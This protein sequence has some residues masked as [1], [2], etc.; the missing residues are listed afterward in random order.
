MVRSDYCS[1]P[2]AEPTLKSVRGV[3]RP[4]RKE[5]AMLVDSNSS[6]P[7]A[8]VVDPIRGLCHDM[9]QPLAAI[10][11]LAETAGSDPQR[12]LDL[13]ADQARW[14][15]SLVDD[16]LVDAAGDDAGQVDVTACATRRGRRAA[17][18]DRL[19]AGPRRDRRGDGHRPPG[20]PHPGH[21]LPRRQRRPRG[22]R[23]TGRSSSTSRST[24][25]ATSRSPCATTVRGWATWRPGRHWGSPSPARSSRPSAARWTCARAARAVWSPPSAC[26]EY[27]AGPSPREA[28]AMRIVICDDHVLLTEAMVI[29]FADHGHDVVAT[30]TSPVRGRGAGPGAPSGRVPAG[31]ELPRRQQPRRHRPHPRDRNPGGDD[32][33]L[34]RARH[35]GPEPSRRA[36]RATSASGSR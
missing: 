15:A 11:M 2:R 20:R 4:I 5:T 13:I 32:V 29:A 28:G 24:R 23:R 17:P 8:R 22:R 6:V 16:V 33:G 7:P 9:R 26:G 1:T 12:R 35:R 27:R 14:L 10:L 36:P 31:R 25:T 30:G 3:D 21:L 19:P 34:D 18:L